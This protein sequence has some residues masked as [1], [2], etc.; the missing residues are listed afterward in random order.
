MPDGITS[1]P[2]GLKNFGLPGPQPALRESNKHYIA[3][4]DWHEANQLRSRRR[5]LDRP[6]ILGEDTSPEDQRTNP[7]PPPAEPI[8]HPPESRLAPQQQ[9]PAFDPRLILGDNGIVGP[10]PNP[11]RNLSVI[12]WT[13]NLPPSIRTHLEQQHTQ[14]VPPPITTYLDQQHTQST[15]SPISTYLWQQPRRN[16]PPPPTRPFDRQLELISLIEENHNSSRNSFAEAQHNV[17]SSLPSRSSALQVRNFSER[18]F[19][20]GIIERDLPRQPLSQEVQFAPIPTP[21]RNH[22]VTPSSLRR[23]SLVVTAGSGR[24]FRS[25]SSLF[26]SSFAL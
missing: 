6:S 26:K 9:L 2:P 12:A 7:N 23:G 17:R 5:Q 13:E 1:R 24:S 3:R 22:N 8:S 20:E 10:S 14:G 11:S 19:S 16:P 15:P 4:C 21:T 18:D 25:I